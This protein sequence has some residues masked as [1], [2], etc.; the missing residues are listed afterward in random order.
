MKAD[1]SLHAISSLMFIRNQIVWH[2][3][4]AG[5]DLDGLIVAEFRKKLSLMFCDQ[6]IAQL[7]Q[8]TIHN[9]IEFI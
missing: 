9:E 2:A 6:G 8:I 4:G 7:G 5:N 1:A 3:G